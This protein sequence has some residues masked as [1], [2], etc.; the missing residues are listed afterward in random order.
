MDNISRTCLG[1][2]IFIEVIA[3]LKHLTFNYYVYL[4]RM[5]LHL[6]AEEM[7]SCMID[8]MIL[9]TGY[10]SYQYLGVG[11]YS[12][13]FRD[14]LSAIMTKLRTAI[15]IVK[16][17]I[18]FE[19]SFEIPVLNKVMFISFF[20]ILTLILMNTFISV[21]N[22]AMEAVKDNNVSKARKRLLYDAE[23]NAYFWRRIGILFRF[24]RKDISQMPRKQQACKLKGMYYTWCHIYT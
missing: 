10:A 11:A 21:I 24:G 3:V 12:F 18:Y 6:A 7:T 16:M 20:V 9:I 13:A 15:A 2:L 14:M 1:F 22:N 5:T 23:L 17:N 19:S 8:I 4:M